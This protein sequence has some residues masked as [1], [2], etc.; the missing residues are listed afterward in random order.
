MCVYF[1]FLLL[2]NSQ[3]LRQRTVRLESNGLKMRSN[4]GALG[5]ATV[6][7]EQSEGNKGCICP[8]IYFFF[9]VQH[10]AWRCQLLEPVPVILHIL[11]VP[12][13]CACFSVLVYVIS[14]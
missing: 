14:R 8:T 10:Q 13:L 7:K 3:F 11:V 12:V 1:F 2:K 4:L 5:N 6:E 9:S